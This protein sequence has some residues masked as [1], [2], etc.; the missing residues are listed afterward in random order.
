MSLQTSVRP[1]RRPRPP[2]HRA[3]PARPVRSTARPYRA[4]GAT[5]AHQLRR[6]AKRLGLITNRPQP[7]TRRSLSRQGRAGRGSLLQAQVRNVV[8][9]ATT[10][11][12]A[13][14]AVAMLA[15][16][17]AALLARLWLY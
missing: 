9:L 1:A 14:F 11:G 2:A 10:P 16:M 8:R 6:T 7:V 12:P 13:Y 17:A 4:Q 5:V 3:R 15:G